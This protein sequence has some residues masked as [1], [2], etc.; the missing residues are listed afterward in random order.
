[1]SPS[2][3]LE[4]IIS[5]LRRYEMA[6]AINEFM[7]DE[8][9]RDPVRYGRLIKENSQLADKIRELKLKRDNLREVVNNGHPSK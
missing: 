3:E 8:T 2:A 1:M 6:L 5:D 9:M 7:A 4:K